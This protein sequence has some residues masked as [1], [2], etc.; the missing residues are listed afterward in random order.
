MSLNHR[1]KWDTPPL[2]MPK[3]KMTKKSP[4][5]NK[6]ISIFKIK[7][8]HWNS[9]HR[10]TIWDTQDVQVYTHLN[11]Y[12]CQ[13]LVSAIL[14][15]KSKIL[16]IKNSTINSLILNKRRRC[17]EMLSV[18]LVRVFLHKDSI[19]ESKISMTFKSQKFS[20]QKLFRTLTLAYIKHRSR[21]LRRKL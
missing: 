1:W 10:P 6:T 18:T 2:K 21:R 12:Y 3:V 15:Q 14:H 19:I 13:I 5:M 17:N 16:Y 7:I 11:P 8:K 9:I 20:S 4:Q